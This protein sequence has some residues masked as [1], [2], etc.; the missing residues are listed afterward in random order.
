MIR[1]GTWRRL[2][3]SIGRKPVRRLK[4]RPLVER[5]ET[6]LTPANVDVLSGH[7]DTFLTG[8]N[9]Q[10][11]T[12][13]PANV[14]AV[15]FGTL[16]S[17]PIDGQA[18][19][20]P[21]YKANLAIPSQGTHNVAF[22]ATE[23]DSVYAFD[24]DT[25][26]QIWHDSFIDPAHGITTTPY[27]ELSTPD[28]F[29]EIGITGTPVIDAAT[30]TLYV[31]VK[32]REVRTDGGVH[33][34]QKLHALDLATGA[35]KFGGPYQL[36][37]THVATPGAVPVF[38]NETTT[39]VVPGSGGE[40]S[41]GANPLVP[42]SAEKEN[43]R[44]SLQLI[45]NVVYAIFASHA[46]FRP[47]H[48]WI[49]GFDKTTL[50]P[51][52]VFNTAPNAD[53][54]AIWESGGGLSFDGTYLY[55]ATGNGFGANAYDP[56]HGNYSESVLKLD[57]TPNWSPTNPQMMTVVDYFTPFNWQTLDSQ[58]ADLGSGGVMLLPDS[59]GSTAHRHLLIETGKQ[60]RIYL[61][62]RDNMGQL[63]NQGTGPD[64]VVQTVTA[65]Q[66][67]VWGN[68]AFFQVNATTGIIYYHGQNDVL[69]GYYITNGHI[70]DTPADIL[71]SS[72]SSHFPGTQ[73]SVSADG[74]ADPLNPVNG[75][76]WELQVDNAV[77]RIQGVSDNTTAG[78]ATLRAF[79][80]TNLS[81]ELY[82]SNQTGQR[83]FFG[84]SVKFTVPVVTNGHVLAGTADHFS[85]L[86]LFPAET[87]APAAPSNL[88]ATVQATSQG[89]RVLL[90]WTN[91]APDPGADPTGIEIFR[92]TDGVNFT[93]LNTVNRNQTTFTDTG[94]FQFGQTYYYQVVAVNQAGASAPSN[95]VSII[96][97]IPSPVLFVTGSGASSLYLAWTNVPAD[98]YVVERSTD[99]TTFTPIAT[100]P[101]SQLS[102][103][104]TGLT[105]GLYAY[106]IHAFTN[107]GAESLSNVRGAW[108]GPTID[109]GTPA[110]GG[111]SN[112]TDL[113]ANGS[114]FF[115]TNLLE[116]TSAPG[117]AGS[118]FS[119]TR[120]T[121]ANFTTTFDVRLHE[122]TQPNYADGF[123]FVLQANAPTALGSAGAGI[124]YQGI[125]HSVAVV[126]STFQHPGDP[127]T[128][129]VGLALNGAA[130]V[131]RVDTTP[132]G[133]LLNS[134]DAKQIDLTYDGSTLTVRVQ[135]ILQPQLVFTTS[136]AVNITQVIGSDTAYVGLAGSSGS[137]G[138]WELEDVLS[139][140]YTSQVA[141]PGGPTNLQAGTPPSGG[142]E[143]T[144]QPN[145]FNETGF[146]IERAPEG[147]AF[148]EIATVGHVTSYTDTPPQGGAYTY[149]VRAYNGAGNS[150]Y[151]NPV[152]V[153]YL[154]PEAPVALKVTSATSTGVT[155]QWYE[156]D[157][158]TTGYQIE[159]STDGTK[160]TPIATVSDP[161]IFTYTDTTV[162]LPN[163]YFY[164]VRAL[165]GFGASLPSNTVQ[166]TLQLRTQPVLY[167]RF[168]EISGTATQDH[169]G[170]NNN[171][172]LAGGVT[173][174]GGLPGFG[175][176]LHFDGTGYVTAADAAILDPQ[177]QI[178]VS[179]WVNADTWAG[180]NR[181]I[182]QKGNSDNQYRLL[183]EGG[184]LKWDLAGIG[185]VTA[186]LPS[187][188]V[189][190]NVT[191]TYNG[192]V[193]TLYVDG[194][195]VA[196]QAAGGL[197]AVTGDPLTVA[198]KNGTA[199]TGDNFIGTIDEVRVYQRALS[200]AEVQLLPFTDTDVGNVAAAGS[201]AISSGSVS[202]GNAVYSIAGSGD[203]IW[204]NADA[205]NFAYQPLHGNAVITARVT[206]VTLTDYWAK[207]VVMFRQTLDAG[208]SFVDLVLTH[209]DPN[210]SLDHSETSLQ[211]RQT[212][213]GGPAADDQG[214]GSAPLPY[215]IR[216]T[217]NGN[218][219]TAEKSADGVNWVLVATQTTPMNTDI[220]VGLGVTA[221]N[222]SGVLNT[223]VFDHVSVV[224]G[225][226][227]G[228]PLL[229]PWSSPAGSSP[230]APPAPGRD[231][232][233]SGSGGVAPAAPWSPALVSSPAAPP[234]FAPAAASQPPGD[235]RSPSLPG[236]LSAVAA[237]LAAPQG[238]PA[239]TDFR[240]AGSSDAVPTPPSSA[241]LVDA[242]L[243]GS[244]TPARDAAGGR[245]ATALPG[246]DTDAVDQV[247]AQD[248]LGELL[249]YGDVP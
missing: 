180:G 164:R 76:V 236:G 227:G 80:P 135:D 62:D 228:E 86:G 243:P 57:P 193:M 91:P 245:A 123:A 111:F 196:S 213:N 60:G 248:D 88:S 117:Q 195:V 190:H 54:V 78:P 33:Y 240:P 82:D 17:A 174:V 72:F 199:T 69:K 237:A 97:P 139:W 10:E 204:N 64:L 44:M 189:W 119:N 29:P 120:I 131:T 210:P 232:L 99:G 114:A 81:T 234:D 7:Y 231:R 246:A 49:I 130:P 138:F 206:S 26:A 66:T 113:T 116:L 163:T 207:G 55:V 108:V 197:L 106:R 128:T 3:K 143:L 11:T 152:V 63:N 36:G 160:F 186:A 147:G 19:A 208:S 14:N 73:P 87:A 148:T 59:V 211:W 8:A 198:T 244:D 150:F 18:Y 20:Q 112:V 175:N 137:G 109:H 93:L 170:L 9:L 136:F 74:T 144:W 34:V 75:I 149:R 110:T 35:D 241:P 188:G 95:T 133:L 218:L 158:S 31:V 1:T 45:G 203:D 153:S 115:S 39:I 96:A 200:Q 209:T 145:S 102:Y 169:S 187:T 154:V 239:S 25:G 161:N 56:A 173:H 21:L 172:T 168:D 224:D 194:S 42:F 30:S 37:D 121:D 191:G 177:F 233:P 84:G 247:F 212:P 100:V 230:A 79:S 47:Y 83:D 67:G 219:F 68:P 4:S 156:Y 155:L 105:P 101:P 165:N 90:S 6:R 61:I 124:G 12:L 22:I 2:R 126:F 92:S 157:P 183:E 28:L 13:V 238:A 129:S 103:T 71:K 178:T 171:G 217:R 249:L 229:P 184:V 58:D 104:D 122:G 32:T 127:S 46:D 216:L 202:G 15:N 222:N 70:D 182:L 98:Y 89:S 50:Q 134:Q 226:E 51:V 125:N 38:A 107:S 65:G 146:R 221:H 40:S 142:V 179:A 162:I 235:T 24:A 176:G 192:A 215:W 85:V 167:Y 118:A 214:P 220:F 225:P 242:S 52:K 181:R 94:P 41:G 27:Q 159:R 205:F 185:A 43:E 77:G 141:V 5:L 23:H 201:A 140:R 48:G 166:A 16:F 132:S 151:S 53:G 223:S